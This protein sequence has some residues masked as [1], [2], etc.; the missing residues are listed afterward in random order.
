MIMKQYFFYALLLLAFVQQADA[1]NGYQKLPSGA[2]YKVITHV[3]GTQVKTND[4]VSF[5]VI[6]KTEKDS[7]LFSSYSIG[8]PI[9][10]QVVASTNIGDLMDVFPLLSVQDSAEVHVPTDSIF[11]GH[12]ESRPPFFQKGSN[13]V[14]V[15][16]VVKTQS[17]EDAMAER[18]AGLAK[19]KTDEA[20]AAD[21]YIVD[22]KLT[23]VTTPSGLKYHIITPSIK[24]KPLAGDTIIVNYIGRTIDGKVFDTNMEEAAKAFGLP[25]NH[26]FEPFRVEIGKGN[27]IPGW[28]EGML[29]L[30][31]GSKATLLIPSALGYGEKGAGQDIKP[32]S[33]LL[34]D[35]EMIKIL[36]LKRK[37]V[38]PVAKAGAKHVVKKG[39]ATKKAT[40]TTKTT[41]TAKKA[42]P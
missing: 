10:V 9:Q 39:T 23:F 3:N 27:V 2:S 19:L 22:H 20:L 42:T 11:K 24:R 40:T 4:V 18:N 35:V 34:F 32:F 15:V 8:H 37:P 38:K 7:I 14:M 21:K 1:Q 5:Q 36:P 26:P 41:T 31:E 12:E 28:D 17:L 25:A 30:G 6:Q 13:L 33:T 29:L 16:K